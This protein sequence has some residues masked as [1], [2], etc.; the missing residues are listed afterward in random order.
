MARTPFHRSDRVAAML[1]REVAVLVHE[2]VRSRLVPESSVSDV[3]LSPDLSA[4]TVFVTALHSTEAELAIK[5]LNEQAKHYRQ[6][7]A[8]QLKLR[9]M[10]SLKF[11][12]DDSVDRG[13][14]IDALLKGLN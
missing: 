9:Q 13:E 11:K 2:D 5:L 7:L 10:P 14:R 1:R 12:Y 4:A 8:K 3:E 6:H